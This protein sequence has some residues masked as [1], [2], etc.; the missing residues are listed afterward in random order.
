KISVFNSAC[1]RFYAPSDLCGFGGMR[2]EHIRSCPLW[3]NEFS[4]YDCVFVST[5]SDTEGIRGLN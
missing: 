5:G 2:V 4:R 1:S 3:R